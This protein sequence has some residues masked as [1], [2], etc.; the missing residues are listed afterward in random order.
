MHDNDLAPYERWARLRFAVVGPFPES[1]P[2][3]RM[4]KKTLANLAKQPWRH[5][6]KSAHYVHFSQTTIERWFY[7]AK[8]AANPMEALRRRVRCDAGVSR[9]CSDA[10]VGYLQQQY[11]DYPTWTYWL[12]HGNVVTYV[13]QPATQTTPESPAQTSTI[14][15]RMLRLNWGPHSG[16]VTSGS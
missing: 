15:F 9:V 3:G 16:D 7:L 1:S 12:H 11:V 2:E 10:L 13:E 6:T 8:N 4:L 5:P 14:S